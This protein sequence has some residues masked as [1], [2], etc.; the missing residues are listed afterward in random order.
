MRLIYKQWTNIVNW[1]C[2]APIRRLVSSVGPPSDS[3]RSDALGLS[4]PFDVEVFYDGGC[5]ICIREI[6]LLRR[7]DHRGR[8]RFTDIAAPEFDAQSVGVGFKALMDRIHGRLPDGTLVE[9]VEV[10]RR[11][12]SAVGYPTV[13]AASRLPGIAQ[14]LDLAYSL[15]AKNR[16]RLTGRCSDGSCELHSPQATPAKR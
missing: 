2:V 11:L 6:N 7:L 13:V 15:F 1:T 10:F 16:L 12:Y 4:A 3:A 14:L 9:G 5:P 8:I